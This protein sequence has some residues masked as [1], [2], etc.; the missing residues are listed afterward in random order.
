MGS[1]HWQSLRN[2]F[3]AVCELPPTQWRAKLEQLTDDPALVEEAMAMLE[4]QTSGFERA[5]QPLRD[6]IGGIDESELSVGDQVGMW[7]LTG[8]IASGGMGTVFVAERADGLFRQRVAIKLLRGRS[9]TPMLEQRLAAERQILAELQHPSIARLYDGGTTP[10]GRP[11]LVMEHIE[12]QPLDAWCEAQ[13]L[14]LRERVAL[15]LRVCD[16]VQAAHRRLVVHCDLK[17]GNVLVRADGQPVLLDFGIARLLGQDSGDADGFCTPAYASPELRRGGAPVGTSSDIFSLGALLA[18]LLS[19]RAIQRPSREPDAPV[20]LPSGWAEE[21]CAWK[22]RLRGDLD[23]IVARACAGDPQRRYAAV[24][25]LAA[26]LQAWLQHRPVVAVGGGRG[27]HALRFLQRHR[28]AAALSALAV[29]ALSAGLAIALWQARVA[30]DQRDTALV[31][32]AK[33]RAVLDFMTGLFEQADPA[34]ARGRDPSARELLA[35][36]GARMRGRFDDQPEVR[37]EL[38]GAMADAHRGLGDYAQALPLAVEA[39]SLAARVG[40]ED[41]THSLQLGRARILH[42]LGRYPEALSILEPL[43]AA[44]V[45]AATA[46]APEMRAA[47]AHARALALQA[48]NR[49]DDAERAY[50]LALAQRTAAFG[51]GDRRTQETAFRLVS[52]HVLRKQLDQ[53]EPLARATLDAVRASTDALDPHRAEAI[54][55]LAMVLANTGPLDEA[56]ALRR[57]E[58]AIREAAFG[59]AHP[60][61]VGARND[62]AGVLHAQG[63]YDAAGAIYRE[64][65]AARIAHY[66]AGHPAVATAANNLAVA[67]LEAGRFAAALEPARQALAI[68]SATYGTAHHGTATSLHTLGAVEL[69]LGDPA[70]L[71]HL[72]RAIAAWEAAMGPDNPS[73]VS[74]LRDLARAQLVFGTAADCAAAERAWAL[75]HGQAPERRAYVDAVRNA[76]AV[77]AGRPGAQAGLDAAIVAL[78]GLVA[79]DD[80]RLRRIEALLAAMPRTAAH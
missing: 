79:E 21:G 15:F 24:Q 11:Y 32:A 36:G 80:S 64:V 37:A 4:A 8:R 50:A 35:A 31:E 40:A 72:A 70:A 74:P 53:A 66:G 51:A 10:A 18:E 2:L 59:P 29:V 19:R 58:L 47:V 39:E 7:R 34:Q 13:A 56:E 30:R 46:E 28:L 71:D 22:P 73:L 49:L 42:H 20:P 68:R 78:R 76:C 1:I 23:A 62:L 5:L 61:A 14:G 55:A 3:E 12:G 65:L 48:T 52:L 9:A 77:A 67:G 17:P 44:L 54:E 33:S 16:A 60:S 45:D 41:L 57:E 6:W 43:Q 27:Y 25:E 38:L 75:S 69:E 63:R 26:D